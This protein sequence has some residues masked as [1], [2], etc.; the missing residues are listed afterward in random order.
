MGLPCMCMCEWVW[1]FDLTTTNSRF[2]E[3]FK[4]P[5]WMCLWQ[6][7]SFQRAHTHTHHFV[8]GCPMYKLW[9]AV[10][11]CLCA[12][13]LI[14]W[15]HVFFKF[16]RFRCSMKSS[17]KIYD[18]KFHNLL[19]IL[20]H[21]Q[22]MRI[23]R[24]VY[25][26]FSNKK[27]KIRIQTTHF[28]RTIDWQFNWKI[29]QHTVINMVNTYTCTHACNTLMNAHSVPFKMQRLL[30]LYSSASYRHT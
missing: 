9:K 23:L 7:I 22:L 14:R 13:L 12:C 25:V 19:Q 20:H 2:A 10:C 4:V 30:P 17:I 18:W 1:V 21:F 27:G 16:D 5:F 8:W 26:D 6:S 28:D 11:V 29:Q 15:G 3:P 24:W